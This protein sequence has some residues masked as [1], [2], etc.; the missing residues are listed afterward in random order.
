[1]VKTNRSTLHTRHT[2]VCHAR[3]QWHDTRRTAATTRQAF[4]R[5]RHL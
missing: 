3:Q 1:M 2:T 5:W 4:T